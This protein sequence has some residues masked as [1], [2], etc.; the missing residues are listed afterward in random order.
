LYQELIEYEAEIAEGRYEKKATDYHVI[1]WARPKVDTG[2]LADL[3]VSQVL[4]EVRDSGTKTGKPLVYGP[5]IRDERITTEV[6]A[7]RIGQI[8]LAGS[9]QMSPSV[10]IRLPLNRWLRAGD[11]IRITG[12]ILD[13]EIPDS[14]AFQATEVRKIFEPETG[15]SWDVVASA[16]DKIGDIFMRGIGG[17][18]LETKVGIVVAVYRNEI[19]GRVYD[20]SVGGQTLYGLKAY[21]LL[22][23]LMVGETVQVS[24]IT[25]GAMSYMIVARTTEVFPEER[26]CYV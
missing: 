20:V 26:I 7:R 16:P 10:K 6:M 24:K 14:R 3:T 17:D 23:E 5:S 1:V 8:T 2:P 22:G 9:V 21:P 15:K 19:G 12:D 4:L 13:F 18:P 25:R 11:G